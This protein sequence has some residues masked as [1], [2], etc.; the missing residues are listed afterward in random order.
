MLQDSL[1]RFDLSPELV[2][3]AREAEFREALSTDVPQAILLVVQQF[4][5]SF[6]EVLEAAQKTGSDIPIIAIL[7]NGGE[8]DG[9]DLLRRGACN[10]FLESELMCIPPSLYLAIRARNRSADVNQTVTR[11]ASFD[12][13][14]NQLARSAE[15][16]IGNLIDLVT[17]V[18]IKGTILYESPAI[19]PQLGYSEEELIGRNAFAMIHPLD[20]P[21][22][23]PI[24]MVA[25]ATPGV[26][27]DARFRF[28]H[29]NGSWRTLESVGKAV[30]TKEGARHVIVTSRDITNESR[31][32]VTI[33]NTEARF[34]DVVEGLGEGVVVSD[35]H[36]KILYANKQMEEFLGYD[37]TEMLGKNFYEL[38]LPR[39]A[40]SAYQT[41]KE[42]WLMGHRGEYELSVYRKGGVS[43]W[44]HVNFSPYRDRDGR[45]IGTLAAFTDI[46]KRKEA[47]EE[48]QRTLERLQIERDR[49]EEMNRLKTSFLSN[50][51]HEIR[52]PL[53]SIL[54]FS[55]LLTE[56]LEGTEFADYA[57]TI[58]TSGRRLFETIEGILDLS[59]VE[60]NTVVMTP[61]PISLNVEAQR[62]ISMLEPQAKENKVDV[63][64][65]A[66]Q[67]VSATLDPHYLG[68]ILLNIIGNAIKFSP[69]GLVRVLIGNPNSEGFSEI[70]VLDTGVG[71]S[72]EFLP[73]LFEEFYQESSGLARKFEGTGLGLRIAKRLVELMGGS[74]VV[75]S[76]K[77]KGSSF[78]ISLPVNAN[79]PS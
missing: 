27:H 15:A 51:S 73:R 36:D 21:R 58:R 57:T 10:Y 41:Q 43:L 26:P 11:P 59:R 45:I 42:R 48:V 71:I 67:E 28:K 12:L 30:E 47:E 40:W 50:V 65:E 22:V 24:F 77:G 44:M 19:M 29:K 9:M 37:A 7:P 64:L 52:T 13:A 2:V 46:T 25:L 54:G 5:L 33:G 66:P 4:D 1:R 55:S 16:L 79:G 38:L 78:T 18:D 63:R 20:V 53:N 61:R 62:A 6:G 69:N 17:E 70:R 74:I 72:E 35:A 8:S 14:P 60:S 49:A 56:M 31:K 23:M 68:R 39:G 34:M 76:E 3:A 32:P 75:E